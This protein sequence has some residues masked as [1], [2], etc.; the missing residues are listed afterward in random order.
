MLASYETGWKLWGW[1][2]YCMVSRN[3]WFKGASPIWYSNNN[4]SD[5]NTTRYIYLFI[6]SLR[7]TANERR[8]FLRQGITLI[9]AN[10]AAFNQIINAIIS[11]YS[12]FSRHMPEDLLLPWM[13]S[14]LHQQNG[15]DVSNRYF[16]PRHSVNPQTIMPLPINV[17]PRGTLRQLQ[18]SDL[19]HTMDN[20]VEYYEHIKNGAGMKR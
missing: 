19:V 14:D 9:G 4:V 17:D 5:W 6:I 2:G 11:V 3:Y 10:S 18:S 1:R 8:R 16:E 15:I 13:P 20:N 7:G 12:G